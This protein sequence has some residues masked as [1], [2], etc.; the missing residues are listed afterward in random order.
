MTDHLSVSRAY[1]VIDA[2]LADSSPAVP[3]QRIINDG[4]SMTTSKL[5][6]PYYFGFTVKN[7]PHDAADIDGGL[8]KTNTSSLTVNT[9]ND[10]FCT[11]YLAYSTWDGRMLYVDR[12]SLPDIDHEKKNDIAIKIYKLLATIACQLGCARLSWTQREKPDDTFSGHVPEFCEEWLFLKMDRRAMEAY[13]GDSSL[14]VT[15]PSATTMCLDR[16]T[17]ERAIQSSLKEGLNSRENSNV[18]LRLASEEDDMNKIGEL[19]QGLAVYEKEPY[20]VNGEYEF[21]IDVEVAY[22]SLD[23]R[24]RISHSLLFCCFCAF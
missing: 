8:A 6:I 1:E 18:F 7:S 21:D 3:A 19:V 22:A 13:V 2:V 11:F 12:L 4:S 16:A 15:S 17:V 9:I 10:G 20:A 5:S 23:I 14:S 24:I